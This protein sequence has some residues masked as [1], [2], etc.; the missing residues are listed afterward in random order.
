MPS[1]KS[2]LVGPTV[3]P[4]DLEE[5]AWKHYFEN[6]TCPASP[7]IINLIKVLLAAEDE[8]KRA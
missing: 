7:E 1:L 3:P 2:Q 5:R 6:H 4:D 8:Q